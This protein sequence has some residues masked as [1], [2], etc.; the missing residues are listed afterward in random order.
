MLNLLVKAVSENPDLL[1]AQEEKRGGCTSRM[2][3]SK[4]IRIH[5]RAVQ[6]FQAQFICVCVEERVKIQKESVDS[7][8]LRP[9]ISSC[10]KG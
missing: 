2:N 1:V 8:D 7:T 9:I 4:V 6:I 10:I 3:M 5:P